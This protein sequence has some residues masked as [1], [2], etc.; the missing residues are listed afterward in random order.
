MPV[1]T[2]NTAQEAMASLMRTEHPMAELSR[3]PQ[4]AALRGSSVGFWV[5]AD[6]DLDLPIYSMAEAYEEASYT[7]R[8]EWIDEHYGPCSLLHARHEVLLGCTMEVHIL[9]YMDDQFAIAVFCQHMGE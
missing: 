4:A 7:A 8:E 3:W 2:Y 6:R 1:Q 5:A 9:R